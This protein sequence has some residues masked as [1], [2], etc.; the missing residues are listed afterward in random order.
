M[1]AGPW[2]ATQNAVQRVWL[3]NLEIWPSPELGGAEKWQN[4]QSC[5]G[6]PLESWRFWRFLTSLGLGC[7]KVP[8]LTTLQGSPLG[9]LAVLPD[10]ENLKSQFYQVFFTMGLRV[11][12]SWQLD[13]EI[14]KFFQVFF[15]ERARVSLFV[16][17]SSLGLDF[18]KNWTWTGLGLTSVRLGLTWVRRKSDPAP[19][20]F[21][22]RSGRIYARFCKVTNTPLHYRPRMMT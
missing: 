10:F 3:G 1:S 2:P 19:K 7:W 16:F 13:L 6:P 21:R 5:K 22:R 17:D 15:C 14:S 4:W 8:K 9:E 11:Y 20:P 12:P 18:D